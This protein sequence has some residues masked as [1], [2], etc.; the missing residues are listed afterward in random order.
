M[1]TNTLDILIVGAGPTGL[2]LATALAA[3]GMQPTVVDRQA[4]GTNTSRAAVVHARTLEVL[5]P[6]GV[7]ERLVREAL[8]AR[9]WMA[10]G[11]RAQLPPE[12]LC[13]WACLKAGAT[14]RHQKSSH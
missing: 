13:P 12:F 4:A 14:V 5:E 6:T 9:R 3:R 1:R 2:T 7:S 8:P 10:P 11:R